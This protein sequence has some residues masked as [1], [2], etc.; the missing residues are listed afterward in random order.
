LDARHYYAD[1]ALERYESEEAERRYSE[2]LRAA[3]D[4]GDMWEAAAEMQG[5]A[6]GIAGQ[7]RYKKALRLNGAA[8]R[9]WEEIGATIPHIAFWDTLME[10]N[11]GRAK[12]KLGEKAAALENEGQKMGF[13]RAVEYAL[14]FEKD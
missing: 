5:M 14:D 10:R 12:K 4:Y 2:A 6:M 1:C 3:L 7:G 9:E 13:E 8:L 11:I